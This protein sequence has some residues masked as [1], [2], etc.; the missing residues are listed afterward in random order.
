[1]SCKKQVGKDG[2]VVEVCSPTVDSGPAGPALVEQDQVGNTGL[3][4]Q[5]MDTPQQLMGTTPMTIAGDNVLQGLMGLGGEGLGALEKTAGPNG[6]FLSKKLPNVGRVNGGVQKVNNVLA[7]I[8]LAGGAVTVADAIFNDEKESEERAVLGLEGAFSAA[9]G[10]LGMAGWAPSMAAAC[11]PASAVAGSAAM[12]L[13][14]GR[15]LDG[16]ADSVGDKIAGMGMNSDDAAKAAR[17][18]HSLSGLMGSGAAELDRRHSTGLGELEATLTGRDLSALSDERRELE[19]ERM[20]QKYSPGH[21][22][23]NVIEAIAGVKDDLLYDEDDL[24]YER[25]VGWKINEGIEAVGEWFD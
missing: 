21:N 12:G 9:A 14:A 18:D 25:T 15:Y 5:L 16:F 4:E 20:G 1:M 10:G 6:M 11:N 24:Q 8:G 3:I 23:N 22:I 2:K 17:K 7:P 13:T 19:Y